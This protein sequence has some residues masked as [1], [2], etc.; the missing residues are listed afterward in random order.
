VPA[1]HDNDDFDDGVEFVLNQDGGWQPCT[2]VC[3]DVTVTLGPNYQ[4]QPLYLWAWKDGNLDCDFDDWLCEAHGDDVVVVNPDECIIQGYPMTA[5]VNRLCFT[6]PGVLEYGVYDGYFRV[7]LLSFGPS[8]GGEGQE[9]FDCEDAQTVTDFELGET[10]DYVITDLQLPVELMDFSAVSEN[11]KVRLNWT[12]GSEIDNDHFELSRRMIG[13]DWQSLGV[14]IDGAGNS[15]GSRSYGYVD[16]DVE[17]GRTYVYRLITVDVNG[18]RMV[19]SE[20]EASVNAGAAQVSEF[21]LYANYPNPFNPSTTIAYDLR[22]A[23]DVTLNVFDVLGRHVSTLVNGYQAA[24]RYSLAFEANGLPSGVYF[25]R[26]ETAQFTD[27]KKMML[28]K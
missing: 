8:A 23:T 26:L 7:R 2:E 1:V 22:E 18:T 25:Y 10:E 11:G 17:I 3:V 20:T 4:G 19:A 15:A 6:D 24:G 21:K 12:T 5:G 28:L 9:G 16:E 27:M 13:S 14:R